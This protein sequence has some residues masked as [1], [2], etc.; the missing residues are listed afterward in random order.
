MAASPDDFISRAAF[1]KMLEIAFGITPDNKMLKSTVRKPAVS[2]YDF[3]DTAGHWISAEGWLKTAVGFGLVLPEDYPDNMFR[4]E[5]N[6]SRRECIIMV[7]RALGRVFPS[8]YHFGGSLLFKDWSF[9]PN[10]FKGYAYQMAGLNLLIGYPDKTLRQNR[11]ATVA[12]A[13]AFIAR[14]EDEMTRGIDPDI[15]IY[16]TDQYGEGAVEANYYKPAQLIDGIIYIP[17]RALYDA[18]CRVYS[19]A[20]DLLYRWNGKTQIMEFE[21]GVKLQYQPGNKYFGYYST[22]LPHWNDEK[23]LAGEVRLLQGEVMLP[24]YGSKPAGA[25]YIASSVYKSG[26]KRLVIQIR[27]PQKPV[28]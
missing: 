11:D 16:V 28:A 26:E 20:E 27:Y 14:A 19:V 24:V 6:I 8:V 3:H 10:W 13:A 5:G 4:P 21:Y 1:L 17:A 7:I 12:E 23:S 15:R 22:Q 2:V 18:G 9:V 25:A